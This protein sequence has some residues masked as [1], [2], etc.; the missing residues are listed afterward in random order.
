VG[1]QD[2]VVDIHVNARTQT[3]LFE[4]CVED[5]GGSYCYVAE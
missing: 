2:E 4:E 5:R 1:E 3:A